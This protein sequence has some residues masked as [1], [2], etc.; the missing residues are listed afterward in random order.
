MTLKSYLRMLLAAVTLSSVAIGCDDS[1]EDVTPPPADENY[2]FTIEVS[3]INAADATVKVKPSEQQATYYFNVVEKQS[4]DAAASDDAFLQSS[5]EA[6]KAAATEKGKTFADYLKSVISNGVALKKFDKLTPETEYYAYVYGIKTDGTLTSKLAK[7]AFTTEKEGVEPEGLTFEFKVENIT[8]TAA[9]VDVIPSNNEDTYY[10]DVQMVKAF[11]GMTEEEMLAA[12]VED[13]VDVEYLTSGPDGYPAELFEQY[14]PLK[15]GT[16]YYVY[17]VGY[18]A[19]K[20]ATT[21][22][23]THKFTTQAAT[24]EA[25]DLQ[26]AA[27]AGD[28]NNQNTST[29]IYCSALSL[30]A[31]SAKYACLP[32][33]SVDEL[34]AKGASLEDIIDANGEDLAADGLAYLTKEPGLGLTL[35]TFIPST[36]Y[37][38]IFKVV[39][40]G[41][42][43][44]VKSADVTTTADGGETG[45]GPELTLSFRAGD[46]NGANTDTKGY[47][48]AY[49]PT[50]T[51]AY[52][53]VFLTSDVEKILAQGGSYDAIVTQNGTDMSTK[54]GW[55]DALAKNPGIGVTFGGLDP[56]TSFTCI[57]KV[58]DSAGK[59]TTKYVTASTDGGGEAS[60]A[61]KAW[62]GTWTVT[63]TSSETTKAPIEFEVTFNQKVANSS[64]VAV[65]WTTALWRD[66]PAKY[67]SYF[68]TAKFDA[69]TGKC[70][71]ENAQVIF[72][73]DDED[74]TG[75]YLFNIRYAATDGKTYVNNSNQIIGLIGTLDSSKNSAQMVG[76]ELQNQGGEKVG[77]VTSMSHFYWY[78]TG[79]SKDKIYGTNPGAAF[80]AGGAIDYPIGPYAMVKKS[81]ASSIASSITS[82]TSMEYLRDAR[83]LDAGNLSS[84]LSVRMPVLISTK[85]NFAEAQV[86][87][88]NSLSFEK[89]AANYEATISNS[90]IIEKPL[91]LKKH[92]IK[93]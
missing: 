66:D 46:G 32:K 70:Y 27:R 31:A 48:E 36:A 92:F 6:L 7:E 55:L 18:D 75:E 85:Q 74:G 19:D 58:M 2:T 10:F 54:D 21:K 62:L 89:P 72:D 40:A 24:G 60:D 39:S 8:K 9:D 20:G 88:I 38:A 50:A 22:L 44:T 4:F 3:P 76:S 77:E 11:E 64:Y 5:I 67:N 71:F 25:P 68:P 49:A 91:G 16:E 42:M 53:G 51:G 56:G 57:L 78:Y 87:A 43:S 59:S 17:A 29:K 13:Y 28:A 82:V 61:Y 37:T 26:F 47:M 35:G 81:S 30:A 12:I 45:D 41:G 63:S 1:D 23:F 52:Y 90:A 83:V 69:E 80:N 86:S 15:P 93:K 65:G 14:A 34:I 84:I 33:A 79:A 73:L